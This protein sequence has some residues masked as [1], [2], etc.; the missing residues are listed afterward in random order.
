M[1]PYKQGKYLAGS[2]HEVL[3]PDD[4]VDRPPDL[5]V[6][7]NPVYLDEIRR[8]LDVRGLARAELVAV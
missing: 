4:L 8:D 1:N 5:V 2:G 6:A 3:G 7:M